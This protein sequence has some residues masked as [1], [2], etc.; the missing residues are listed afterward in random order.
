MGAVE[1][2]VVVVAGGGIVVMSLG[3][4]KKGVY[5]YHTTADHVGSPF[6]DLGPDVVEEGLGEPMTKNHD[7]VAGVVLKK[8]GHSGPRSNRLGPD[9]MRVEAKFGLTAIGAAGVAELRLH[10]IARDAKSG[11][12]DV[13]SVDWC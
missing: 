3:G 4:I 5:F 8:K 13:S 12:V 10:E 9:F 11:I 2:G 1:V 6:Q 7:A